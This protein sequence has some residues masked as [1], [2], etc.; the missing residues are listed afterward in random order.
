MVFS[1]YTL[2]LTLRTVRALLHT[3]EA[4]PDQTTDQVVN[5]QIRAGW[6]LVEMLRTSE[7]VQ[8]VVPSGRTPNEW[9][10]DLWQVSDDPHAAPGR[11]VE[12]A[13]R[14]EVLA[15]LTGLGRC[16]EPASSPPALICVLNLAEDV[17]GTLN[18]Y[19]VE[20]NMTD[21]VN[22]LLQFGCTATSIRRR[23]GR[24]ERQISPGSPWVTVK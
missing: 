2:A 9:Y 16:S 12:E 7:A 23:G 11:F 5:E 8:S 19:G 4:T 17:V 1:E 6:A 14:P 18:R 24:F 22:R 3:L 10:C 13:M 20:Y 21:A 15:Q